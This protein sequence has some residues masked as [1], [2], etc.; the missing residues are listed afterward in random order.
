MKPTNK[1]LN[2]PQWW[3]ENAPNEHSVVGLYNNDRLDCF[4]WLQPESE[5]CYGNDSLLFYP[6]DIGEKINIY[7]RQA[8]PAFLP[9][10][11]VECELSNCGND[12]ER[13]T[14]KY[15]GESL[16]VV[17]HNYGEQYYRLNSVKFRPIKS[18]REL[19][20]ETA[21]KRGSIDQR[22]WMEALYDSGLFK[23]VEKKK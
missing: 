3:A 15:I 21:M 16:C 10:V 23:L 18:E 1:Q 8:K 19:F 4:H 9:E 13:C 20:I 11:G 14:L 22:E 17:K 12:Y 5:G 7:K 2:D 6:D